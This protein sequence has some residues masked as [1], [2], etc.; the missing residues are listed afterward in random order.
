MG[1]AILVCDDEPAVLALLVAVLE[2][3]GHRVIPAA[4]FE[5]ARAAWRN[6]RSHISLIICDYQ[7]PDGSGL[8]LALQ[9]L[10]EAPDVPV[11]LASGLG[12]A[13]IGIPTC[14]QERILF[15][16]KPFTLNQILGCVEEALSA[17]LA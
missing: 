10:R 5:S 11:I 3:T 7:L 1:E 6:Q 13:E 9:I 15:V 14:L 8:D 16:E 12:G 17:A 2:Q 4:T